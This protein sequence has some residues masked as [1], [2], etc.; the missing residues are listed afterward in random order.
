[1]VTLIGFFSVKLSTVSAGTSAAGPRVATLVA[2]PAPPPTARAYRRALTAARDRPDSGTSSSHDSGADEILF[3][4]T[5]GFLFDAIA[6][7]SGHL[8]VHLNACER[9]GKRSFAFDATALVGVHDRTNDGRTSLRERVSFRGQGT[10]KDRLEFIATL[11]HFRLDLGCSADG[12]RRTG[13]Q[14]VGVC[15]RFRWRGRFHGNGRRYWRGSSRRWC[16]SFRL[17]CRS[18]C[19]SHWLLDRGRWSNGHSIRN[20]SCRRCRRRSP[21]GAGAGAV[22]GATAGGAAG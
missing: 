18:G 13:G 20:R 14:R 11:H 22:V 7:D 5:L 17:W 3:R 21:P 2:T 10:F 15:D 8:A 16:D 9:Q 4:V 1:M 19:R 6:H 12:D